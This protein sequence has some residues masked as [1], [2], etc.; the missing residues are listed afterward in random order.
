[1]IL[2]VPDP[3]KV[4]FGPRPWVISAA[5]LLAHSCTPI[6]EGAQSLDEL[7]HIRLASTPTS[8]REQ[9][10]CVLIG[11]I[12]S[13]NPCSSAHRFL[14][15]PNYPDGGADQSHRPA[16]RWNGQVRS[17]DVDHRDTP[18]F[19]FTVPNSVGQS[20]R[21]AALSMD[22]GNTLTVNMRPGVDA[23]EPDRQI[24]TGRY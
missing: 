13:Q 16:R 1:M 6:T 14:H 23:G 21:R 22:G 24:L 11:A 5:M 2:A 7:D 18:T 8:S 10:H 4:Q 9:L 20:E 17:T 19:G 3:Q 12:E 15:T